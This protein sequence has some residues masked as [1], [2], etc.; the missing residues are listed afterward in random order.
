MSPDIDP[1]LSSAHR[2]LRLR[3]ERFARLFAP[4]LYPL[5][6]AARSIWGNPSGPAPGRLP[7]VSRPG[8][9][10]GGMRRL[11]LLALLAAGALGL[12]T[13]SVAGA[14]RPIECTF[15]GTMDLFSPQPF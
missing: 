13:P 10:L 4:H 2:S 1:L 3:G 14:A 6:A 12:V 7:L 8:G 9:V 15:T 5:R 11:A